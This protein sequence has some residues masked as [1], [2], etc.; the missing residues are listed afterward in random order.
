MTLDV[1][2]P[3]AGFDLSALGIKGAAEHNF[4]RVL[5]NVHK[6]AGTDR[7]AAEPGDVDI[8]RRVQLAKAEKRN[9]QPP[10]A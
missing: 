7:G 2:L 9:I 3:V 4:F 8:A 6:A 10:P 1:Q 5:R